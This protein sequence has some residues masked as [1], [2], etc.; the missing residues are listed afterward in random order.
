MKRAALLLLATIMVFSNSVNVCAADSNETTLS[1]PQKISISIKPDITIELNG[2]IQQFFDANGYLVYPAIYNGTSYLPVRSISTV[3]DK[4]IEW[5]SASKTIF[6]GKTLSDPSGLGTN[7]TET[8]LLRTTQDKTNATSKARYVTAY[9]K[10]DV[11][12]MNDFVIQS[13]SDTNGKIVYPIIYNGTTYLPIRGIGEMLNK[14]I[15]WDGVNGIISIQ[16]VC[17]D[18][19]CE[20]SDTETAVETHLTKEI[21]NIFE[22]EEALYYSATSKTASL[23]TAT[24]QIDKQQLA[25]EISADLEAAQNMTTEMNAL[26]LSGMTETEKLAYESTKAF[27]DSTEYY[28]LIMEN[29][30]YLAAQDADYSMLADTFLYF[31]MESQNKMEDARNMIQAIN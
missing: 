10:P 16:D 11:L 20:E 27:V 30:V 8:N 9:L 21:K 23:T 26:D 1:K 28:I 31:A 5:D 13:F 29:I 19:D 15:Q 3:L 2:E 4:S 18:D 22:K 17:E 12:V 25:T 14:T 24:D 7:N 6:I